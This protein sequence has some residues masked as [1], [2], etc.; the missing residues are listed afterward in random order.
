L[1]DSFGIPNAQPPTPTQT[2]TSGVFSSPTFQTPRAEAPAFDDH[3]SWTPKF[4]EEY[5][6]FN[7]TPGRLISAGTHFADISTPR[8]STA[9]SQKGTLSNAIELEAELASHVHHSIR[10]DLPLPP[11]DASHRLPSSPRDFSLHGTGP[12]D[13]K[14]LTTPRKPRRRLEEA[15]S[16][17][18]A[19]PP[20]STT[21]SSRKLAPKPQTGTMQA[22]QDQIQMSSDTP[23]LPTH[24]NFSTA[25]DDMFAYP[26]TAPAT[27]PI[28]TNTKSFWDPDSSMSGMEMDLDFSASGNVM[29]DP[30]MSHRVSSSV[31]WGRS[32]QMFQDTI[33]MPAFNEDVVQASRRQQPIASKNRMSNAAPIISDSNFGFSGS[34]MSEDPFAVVASSG[35][36]DPGLLFTFP[37]LTSA[38]ITGPQLGPP[39]PS[40]SRPSTGQII[41][42]PYQHQQRE[43]MR[44]QEELRRSRSSKETNTVALP[45]KTSF[46]SPAK[47]SGRPGLQRSS[48]DS[49][50]KLGPARRSGQLS[51]I[52]SRPST[53]ETREN[54]IR[55]RTSPLK[56]QS[57]TSLSSIPESV[58][59]TR[60]A[61]TFS[62]DANGRA[63][64]ET[65]IIVEEPMTMNRRPSSPISDDW[66]SSQH[67]DSDSSTDEDP[68]IL[69]SRNTSFNLPPRRPDRPKIGHFDTSRQF[70]DGRRQSIEEPQRGLNAS[71]TT[72]SK[73]QSNEQESEAET[74]MEDYHGSGD[75][76]TALRK[77]MESRKHGT[78]HQGS[79]QHQFH[80]NNSKRRTST[81]HITPHQKNQQYYN[82][83]SSSN[84]SPTTV[85]DPD[86]ATPSTDRESSRSD[87]TRCICNNRDGDSFMIQ[88]YVK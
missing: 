26:M 75:A 8:P 14:S 50:T 71:G 7:A 29:F 51:N 24:I 36:V 86:L 3:T 58:S 85:S 53:A 80:P 65:K 16:G 40:Y 62:I 1:R 72:S 15:F 27:A 69:P 39:I 48:S 74:V 4:A 59:G 38:S 56:H 81:S 33:N 35:A 12:D 83:T 68:I 11:V 76:T 19:T 47:K 32:N 17:Q 22:D 67:S 60:T 82:S 57:R 23:G 70:V 41:R 30:E 87:S 25:S 46:S 34:T 64:T 20:Q 61:L 45:E 52:A 5:S 28:Y 44:D 77:I 2:P 49:H 88:W 13:K 10:T 73:I 31:D 42:K 37:E 21:K 18:T 79:S 9:S 63:R 54:P 84:I 78:M 43:S 66:A 6:V 55:R